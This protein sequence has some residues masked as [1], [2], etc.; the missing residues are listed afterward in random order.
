MLEKGLNAYPA[1]VNW[2]AGFMPDWL[3]EALY[4]VGAGL[5]ILIMIATLALVLVY[6]LRKIMGHMQCRLGPRVTG[7]FGLLQTAADA[8]KLMQKEDI[9]PANVDRFLFIIAPY[10]VFFSCGMI[11]MVLPLSPTWVLND[12]DVGVLFFVAFGSLAS[13]SLLMAGFS[14]N[15]KYALIGGMRS[16]AQVVSYEV[17]MVLSLLGAVMLAGSISTQ[18]I[19]V[20]QEGLWL[21]FIPRWFIFLQPL[22]FVIYFLCGLAETGQTPF[23]LPEGESELIAGYQSEYSGM[24]FALFYLAEFGNAFAISAMATTLFLGGWH[25]PVIS[26]LPWLWPFIWFMVKALAVTFCMMWVRS[27]WLRFRIDQMMDFAWK[28]LV[29]LS[30]LN[31]FISA[32]EVAI[33][34]S[35]IIARWIGG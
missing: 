13:F 27:T 35:G 34:R 18:Q 23:D 12:L 9:I 4:R 15:N 28:I 30:L 3:A 5:L 11:F 16:V 20:A 19:V 1:V 25:G 29:P 21:G 31:I 10:L 26:F 7:P 14:S 17:P 2:L 22:G 32:G 24:R 6:A 33:I 8:L